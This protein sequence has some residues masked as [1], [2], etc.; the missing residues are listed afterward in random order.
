MTAPTS[1][2]GTGVKLNWTATGAGVPIREFQLQW[3]EDNTSWS[4]ERMLTLPASARSTWFIGSAGKQFGFRLRAIDANGQAEAWPANDAA[5][6]TH[7]FPSTCQPD[8]AE[9]DNTPEQA[10]EISIGNQY[11]RNICGQGDVDWF[12]VNLG[13]HEVVQIRAES[14]NGAAA[15]KISV[16]DADGNV[17]LMSRSATT[18]GSHLLVVFPVEG[19]ETVLVKVESAF[20]DLFGSDVRYG[21]RVDQFYPVY[22]PEIHKNR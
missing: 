15:A 18:P 16:Y 6:I 4:A 3:R 13:G 21:I 2:D 14:L 11:Q 20:P 9:P 17:M 19:R 8:A 22:M 10:V 7:T 12:R 1:Y 5:E